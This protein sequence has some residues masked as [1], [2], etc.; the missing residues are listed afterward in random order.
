[1]I[2]RDR[3]IWPIYL[4]FFIMMANQFVKDIEQQLEK[5]CETTFESILMAIGKY[6]VFVNQGGSHV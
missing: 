1:M 6:F 2:D 5:V 3:V 4:E